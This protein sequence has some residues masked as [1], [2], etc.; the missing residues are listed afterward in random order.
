MSENKVVGIF[1]VFLV[2]TACRLVNRIECLEQPCGG[3]YEGPNI[4]QNLLQ[5]NDIRPRDLVELQIDY[6]MIGVG[7]DDS[8]GHGHMSPK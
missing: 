2:V 4:D 1:L 8:W 6:R 5:A 3:F 7:G